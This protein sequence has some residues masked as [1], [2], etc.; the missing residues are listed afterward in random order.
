[1]ERETD[2]LNKEENKVIYTRRA[3]DKFVAYL[4]KR[5]RKRREIILNTTNE[6]RN[7]FNQI[8]VLIEMI[9]HNK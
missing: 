2:L 4:P 8:N 6:A 9:F 1:M 7:V 3:E 5:V